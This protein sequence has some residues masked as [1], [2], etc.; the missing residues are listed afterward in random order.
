MCPFCFATLALVAAGATSV[1]GVAAL[2][3]KLSRKKS[4]DSSNSNRSDENA[5]DF[6]KA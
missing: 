4:T 1:G 6:G 3:V 5:D 2:A